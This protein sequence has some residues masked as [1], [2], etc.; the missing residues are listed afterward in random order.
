MLYV[1]YDADIRVYYPVS[2][3]QQCS[4][5]SPKQQ[6]FG[7]TNKTKKC[8]SLKL[9]RSDFRAYQEYLLKCLQDK[10]NALNNQLESIIRE[11]NTEITRSTPLFLG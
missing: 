3:P 1:D 8:L 7:V 5:F 4:K 6:I 11:S 10:Y 2:L 9:G